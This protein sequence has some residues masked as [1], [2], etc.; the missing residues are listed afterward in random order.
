[1]EA[2]FA[3]VGDDVFQN[4]LKAVARGT[5]NVEIAHLSRW[6]SLISSKLF[7]ETCAQTPGLSVRWELLIIGSFSYLLIY[8]KTLHCL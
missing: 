7:W 3:R 1:M 6:S 2:G 4:V 8:N 5:A